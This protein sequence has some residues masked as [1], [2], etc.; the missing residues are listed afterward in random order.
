VNLQELLTDTT[1]KPLS[2]E[3]FGYGCT[4]LM[5]L[6]LPIQLAEDPVQ[7][8]DIYNQYYVLHGFLL[9]VNIHKYYYSAELCVS[10]AV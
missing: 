4:A 6:L 3:A 5:T 8:H 2:I 1:L 10:S 9:D 7:K